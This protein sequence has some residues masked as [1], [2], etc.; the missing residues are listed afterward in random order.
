MASTKRNPA[1]QGGAR[2][3]DRAGKLDRREH[4]VLSSAEQDW[5]VRYV[6]DGTRALGSIYA[7]GPQFR[8]V[9]DSDR[10]LGTF[11]SL[12]EARAAI[13]EAATDRLLERAARQRRRA[14]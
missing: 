12:K 11:A 9:T 5:P 1:G 4:N 13:I 2:S 7:D 3:V 10:W 8:A 6:T 14:A